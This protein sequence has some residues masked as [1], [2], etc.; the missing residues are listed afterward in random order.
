MDK[1]HFLAIII[2]VF[3][4]IRTAVKEYFKNERI[5]ILK[6]VDAKK[7]KAIEKYEKE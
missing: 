1:I 7:I 4:I 3:L 2:V 6:D 5:K